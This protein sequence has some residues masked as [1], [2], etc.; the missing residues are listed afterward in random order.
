MVQSMLVHLALKRFLQKTTIN[1]KASDWGVEL[2][3]FNIRLKFIKGITNTLADAL[4][5]L[6]NPEFV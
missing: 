5:R 3:D 2:S 6:I 4:S 1:A